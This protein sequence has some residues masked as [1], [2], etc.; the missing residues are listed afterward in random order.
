MLVWLSWRVSK[1]TLI[2]FC[3]DFRVFCFFF[4]FFLES[5]VIFIYSIS[6]I[7]PS[8]IT[9]NDEAKLLYDMEKLFFYTKNWLYYH[10]LH[11]FDI[12]SFQGKGFPGSHPV[13]LNRSKLTKSDYFDFYGIVNYN[14]FMMCLAIAERWLDLTRFSINLKEVIIPRMCSKMLTCF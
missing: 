9:K 7:L 10:L 13:S 11:K 1:D 12:I 8:N 3:Q 14:N 6:P 4:L 2:I 5:A